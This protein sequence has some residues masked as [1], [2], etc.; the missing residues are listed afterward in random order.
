MQGSGK[1]LAYGLPVLHKLTKK[2][3]Q[4]EKDGVEQD[5]RLKALILAPTRELAVQV[6]DQLKLIAKHTPVKIVPVIGGL[7]PQKQ[8]RLLA[9]RPEIVI[10]TPGR[11]WELINGVRAHTHTRTHTHA[12]TRTRTRARGQGLTGMAWLV[13]A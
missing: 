4:E 8:V 7:A 3:E 9:R 6:S 11:L 5:R 2:R 1:T 10:A 13:G 12:H